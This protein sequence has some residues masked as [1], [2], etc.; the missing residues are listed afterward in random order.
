MKETYFPEINA[1]PVELAPTEEY[2]NLHWEALYNWT[3]GNF[4]ITFND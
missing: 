1:V 4:R 2:D 3:A